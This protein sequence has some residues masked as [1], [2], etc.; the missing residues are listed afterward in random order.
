MPRLPIRPWHV[1]PR[2]AAGA[3]ILNAG[4]SKSGS[5][6][7][8]AAGL[9]GMAATAYP[10]VGG[11]EPPTFVDGLS[12]AEIG[13]GSALLAPVVPTAPV[14]AALTAFS[15]GLMGLYA[16]VPGLRQPGSIR[17]T[18][19]GLPIAKDVWLLGIGLGLLTDTVLRRRRRD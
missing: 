17:P 4:L 15:A 9:H 19:D 18:Q 14:A 13:L 5:D 7:E 3:I 10:P 2:L 16:R 12:K 11:I 8:S 6:E 1:A